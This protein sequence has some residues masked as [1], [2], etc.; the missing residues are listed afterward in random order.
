M[1]PCVDFQVFVQTFDGWE[2]VGNTYLADSS[3]SG[4]EKGH[5][6]SL[7]IL[8]TFYMVIFTEMPRFLLLLQ[9]INGKK[10]D[11]ITRSLGWSPGQRI[12]RVLLNTSC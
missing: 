8:F 1:F 10:Y 7:F 3:T 12:S 2:V 6:L 4:Y 11:M 5:G 9:D